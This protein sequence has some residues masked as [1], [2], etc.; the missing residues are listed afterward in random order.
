MQLK[1]RNGIACDHCGM[2]Y[3]DDFDYF[4]FD[5]HHAESNDNYRSPI[6]HILHS[7]VIFSI[8]VCTSC[9]DQLKDNI[10]KNYG[11]SM[12]PKR[13]V[14]NRLICD[15]T[16]DYM[17]GSFIYY[18]CVIA[19]VRVRLVGQPNICAGCGMKTL[20]NEK[21]CQKCSGIN[22]T[23]LAQVETDERFLELTL[24]EKAY[25]YFVDKAQMVRKIAGE[26]SSKS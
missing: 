13:S 15:L 19:K 1:E 24:S 12:S 3:R 11:K 23:R 2:S 21:P 17:V 9:F 6:E 26:W 16:G 7:D 18:Y 4:S 22:F 8:D 14:S 25:D 10:V 20:D 5:F